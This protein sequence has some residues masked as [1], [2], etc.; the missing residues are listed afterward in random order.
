M[1]TIL[2]RSIMAII[3]ILSIY[4]SLAF[5]ANQGKIIGKVT[6]ADTGEPLIGVNIQLM[7]TSMGTTTDMDGQYVIL[8]IHPGVYTVRYSYVGYETVNKGG[9]YVSI[10]N[11]TWIDVQ[12]HSSVFQGAEVTVVAERPL[13]DENL[14]GSKQIATSEEFKKEPINSVSE[15]LETQAGIFQ[16]S[17]RGDSQVQ[18][19]FLLN[20]ISVNSGLFSDNFSGFNLSAIQEISVLTGGYSAEYGD[21]RA[22]VINV[23]E[24]MSTKGIHGSF[25]SRVRPAGKY[26][27][28]PN[29]Y[30]RDNYD[31][32]NFGLAYWTEQ[33]E[34][35]LSPYYNQDPNELLAQWQ[36]QSTPSDVLGKYTERAEP[37]Y[38]ATLYGGLFQR[39]SFLLSGRYKKGVGIYPQGIAYNPEF[40]VQGYVNIEIS[41]ALQLRV[42]G[43]VGGYE[44]A[45]PN[46]TNFDSWESAQEHQ[47]L[48]LTTVTDPYSDSKY[49]PMGV[50]YDHFPELRSWQQSY[51]RLTHIINQKS[52]YRLVASYLYDSMNRSDRYGV[53]PDSLWS[54]R[55]D[56]YL[57]VTRFRDQG[58]FHG[59]D[60]NLSEVKQLTF[61]YTNQYLVNQE[62]KIGFGVKQYKFDVTHY[63]TS[64][65]GGGRWNLMNVFDGN[66]YEGH[67]YASNLMEY[68]GIRLNVGVRVDFFNQNRDASAN[69]FDPLAIQLS[70]PG[71]DQTQALGIPGDPER[72]PTEMQV[73]VSPRIGITHPLSSVSV[74]RFSYGHFYQRPS[75]SKM[76]GF[77]FVNYTEDEETVLDPYA[78]QT[79][80]MEEWQG[81]YGNPLMTYEKSVQYELGFDYVFKNII[82][83]KMTGYYKDSDREA[84]VITGLYAKNYT[85]TKALMVS[86]G[87]YSDT[88]GLELGIESRLPGMFNMG[89][90]YDV[91]WS[92][93]GEVGYSRLNEPGSVFIDLPKGLRSD[94]GIW[95]GFQKVKAWASV[96]VAPKAGP[97]I[98]GMS[99]LGDIHLYTYFWWR[100]GDPYTYHAPGDLS[101]RENNM[102]WFNIYQFDLK[103]AKSIQIRSSKIEFSADIRNLFDTK[104]LAKLYG[105]DLK[106]Y[107]ENPS[108]PLEDRLPKHS[109]SKENN[110]WHWYTYEVP[111]RQYYLQ[112]K[113]EF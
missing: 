100:E 57:M 112:M 64:Y 8:N 34:N 93:N 48:G 45:S 21:A 22:A 29:M 77:P 97:Q 39:I 52:F 105:D 84:N 19:V 74:V 36:A 10:D 92:F 35:T 63:M 103:L 113:L 73:A 9:E 47:W 72:I 11:T 51:L 41:R 49:N 26:H 53:V 99:P 98:Y 38:E 87:G 46:G 75:W 106:Y 1:K 95:S 85:A 82:K 50:I 7:N 58:Y 5:S 67:F 17:Y 25:Q 16:G 18:T 69:M 14:T 4:P 28:G 108:L 37:E 62:L 56:T 31:I 111:P 86:N 101:T 42:G 110:V 13:I 30:S 23:V 32:V 6:D 107:H 90:G 33:S 96:D 68:P 66:P 89:I 102:R 76:F 88:R 104:I 59:S 54:R 71:H 24:K 81:F 79:T 27:F 65:E 70:T 78:P 55:D 12:L 20:S 40:N 44:S 91:Y 3:L 109:Y 61:D 80:Y 83:A 94:K 2:Y 15:I 60:D 43:F